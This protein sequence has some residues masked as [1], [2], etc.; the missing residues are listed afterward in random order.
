MKIE[1]LNTTSSGEHKVH[2]AVLHVLQKQLLVLW[3]GNV[4]PPLS[5][6]GYDCVTGTSEA[7]HPAVCCSKCKGQYCEQSLLMQVKVQGLVISDEASAAG[8][9]PGLMPQIIP[10]D[11]MGAA[12]LETNT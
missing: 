8:E 9:L 11:L 5:Y 12:R 6:P 4:K 1:V 2:P 3:S 10:T 7:L